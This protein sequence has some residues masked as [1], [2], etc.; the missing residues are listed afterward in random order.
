M[1]RRMDDDYENRDILHAMGRGMN[2]SM[3][4]AQ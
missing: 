4:R 1:R 2:I 3:A